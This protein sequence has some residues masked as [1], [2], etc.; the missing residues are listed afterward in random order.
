MSAPSVPSSAGSVLPVAEVVLPVAEVVLPVE[1]SVLPVVEVVGLGPAGPELTTLHTK[2]LIDEIP[3]R[4]VRTLRHPAAA[5]LTEVESCDDLYESAERLEDVYDAIVDRLAAAAERWGRVIYAVPGSPCVAER[6]VRLLQDD[7]RVEARVHSAMSFA[8]LAWARLGVD[9]LEAGVRLVDGRRFA[10]EAAGERG[11]FLAA[12]CDSPVWLSEIGD[13]LPSPGAD[14]W[15]L[16][17]LGLESE[18]VEKVR[19][20][21][22][23]RFDGADHLTSVFVPRLAEPVAA[24]FVRFSELV[25]T[26]R[27]RCPWDR[28]QTHKSLRRHLLEETYEVLEAID[29]LPEQAGAFPLAGSAP[30]EGGAAEGGAVGCGYGYEDLEEEL[31]DLLFHVFFHARMAAEAGQFTIVDVV[32]S[33]ETK[34]RNRHPH[35]FGDVVAGNSE[36]VRANWERIKRDEKG[37]NSAM[38]GIPDALPA[39]L[40]ALKVQKRAEA[41]GVK[42]EPKAGAAVPA[43]AVA[44]EGASAARRIREFLDE[45]SERW[46][47]EWLGGLLYEAVELARCRLL[48]PESAL[49][50]A[51][52]RAQSEFSAAEGSAEGR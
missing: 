45:D 49:R 31:G 4:Y 38:E 20:A 36:E 21:D 18:R 7:P 3:R 1:D 24:G 17:H 23:L 40:F 29:G 37:R 52:K 44:G 12:Q 22:L 46:G 32:K 42:P 34:L 6:S 51:A 33:V 16:H 15:I 30:A 14:V 13:A 50:L 41:F 11:P 10:V 39:L 35:V 47:E 25:H 26:L 2:R 9:P 19:G 43:E 5:G 27:E 48:D 28:E 8:E